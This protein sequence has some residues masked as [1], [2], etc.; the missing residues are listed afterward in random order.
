MKISQKLILLFL[1]IALLPIVCVGV[2]S[3]STTQRTLTE[4]IEK[5]IKNTAE[6]EALKINNLAEQNYQTLTIFTVRQQLRFNADAYLQT[7]QPAA[8]AALNT[9][10]NDIRLDN[11]N[12]RRIHIADMQGIIIGSS[13]KRFIGKDYADTEV[14]IKGKERSDVSIFF[15]DI[16][17]GLTQ[18]L[19]APVYSSNLTDRQIGVAII[20][21]QAES[22][23]LILQDYSDL[24]ETG[25]AFLQRKLDSGEL[26]YITPSRFNSDLALTPVQQTAA[27]QDYR[28]HTVVETEREITNMPWI[29]V[30]KIDQ[31]EIY[32]PIV[33]LR[34]LSLLIISATALI[35]IGLGFYFSHV[36][37][38]PIKHL[39]DTATRIRQG[40]LKRRVRLE[41]RD[42]IGLLGTA[43]NEM[44]DRLAEANLSLEQKVVQRTQALDQ[45]VKELA[46]A[47]AKD[48]TILSSMGEGL[49]VT[50]KEGLVVLMNPVALE[51]L[52]VTENYVGKDLAVA[53]KLTE[54]DGSPFV[55][56]NSL[57]ILGVSQQ[58]R[59]ISALTITKKD[60]TK[61]F[62][63][64]TVTPVIGDQQII[65]AIAILRD[66]TKE[67]EV[68][69]MKT[70]FISLASHQ[71][72][73][74]LSAIKWFTEMLA[75]GDAGALNKEQG[76]FAANIAAST[77]RMIEL[78]NS[79]LNISR[80]ESGR[81]IVDPK[82]TDL[83]Q[84]L[85][86]IVS[87][88]KG[89]IEERQQNLAV[90]VHH[91]LPMINLD[92]QLIGQVY[93]NLLTN[94]IKYTPKGGEISVFVSRKGEELVSQVSDN[95]YGIPKSEQGKMFQKFFRATN[96]VKVE[97][98]GTGLGMY[99]IKAIVESSG[100]KIWF[101]SEEGKGTT[102]WF[103]LPMSGMKAKA[104]EVSLGS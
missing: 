58:A 59:V 55:L 24:G 95:G 2:L 47:K 23:L 52:E 14:F 30:I 68:D 83:S 101:K 16:D 90:S 104:G 46:T 50:D 17:G 63:Q 72:R 74:P 35:V 20:E 94:A 69:R 15:K 77:Q 13:D 100:G 10:L 42:E 31:D 71:L 54:E 51:L 92:P 86:G 49:I 1:T 57:S 25:E 61:S 41:S 65:G 38:A 56:K 53:A 9:L 67:K 29:L 87:D 84:M 70:E 12:F 27:D 5:Q 98:D 81:I 78:V 44:T 73:T 8:Q 99:L 43:F 93:L 45:K 39:T 26:E 11:R 36:I 60:G 37:T 3:Y 48:E 4:V 76:E 34:N 62:V 80:I 7:K 88:L 79:L 75:T 85:N 19:T 89:K 18:Y 103:S 6:R 96:I 82:P 28:G 102:F 40:D 91:D 32:S 21:N 22:Y 66:T 33:R 97:A 64:M